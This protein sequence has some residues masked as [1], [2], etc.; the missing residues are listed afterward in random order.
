MK[1]RVVTRE[2]LELNKQRILKQ[3]QLLREQNLAPDPPFET[4]QT[5]LKLVVDQIKL[6]V[7]EGWFDIEGIIPGRYYVD[8]A[9]A[10]IVSTSKG[11]DS[12]P[13]RA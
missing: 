10:T 11:R 6:N 7:N 8:T 4:K 9:Q 5:I 2:K 3:S 13:R 12:L 1:E